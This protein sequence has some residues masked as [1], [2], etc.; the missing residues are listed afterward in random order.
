MKEITNKLV[1][2]IIPTYSRAEYID[3]AIQ[4]VLNQTY[5]NIEIIV[6][7]DNNAESEERF[8]LE[9]KMKKYKKKENIIYLKH[10]KNQNGAVA[11]NSGLKKCNGDY[12]T[13]LD[14]D[15]FFLKSR[16][17]ECVNI[18]EKNIEYGG[19]YTGGFIIK[20]NKIQ[21]IFDATKRGNLQY[22][23]LC[24][25][26]IIKTGSN[27]FFRKDAIMPLN[28]FDDEFIRHQDLEYLVRFFR[29]N[30]MIN[31]DTHTVVKDES[32][33]INKPNFEKALN[34]KRMYLEKFEKDIRKYDKKLYIYECNYIQIY[35]KFG[36]SERKI[37]EEELKKYGIKIN[38]IKILIKDFL[39]K[40][41]LKKIYKFIK[42]QPKLKKYNIEIREI[43]K[44]IKRGSKNEK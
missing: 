16:I 22:D 9:N 40:S 21:D 8:F 18:L 5:T 32:S 42:L 13:F 30:K 39:K 4:S 10:E 24:Q 6:V 12:I 17:E 43:D 33:I 11:R 23:V 3:R 28:G 29:N 1:S 44:V 26:P 31:L 36:C 38:K 35:S 7:D 15:D 27:M 34:M 37:I 41:F 2:V 19:C 20:N 14:D 25:T